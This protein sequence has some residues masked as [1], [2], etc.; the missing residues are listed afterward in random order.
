LEIARTEESEAEKI[1]YRSQVLSLELNVLTFLG[2]IINKLRWDP[3]IS[4]E[5]Q[6]SSEKRPSTKL[7]LLT[8]KSVLVCLGGLAE[9]DKARKSFK[10]R[11]V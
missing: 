9:V 3:S 7:P 2:N 11:R 1:A 4:G 5:L 10:A 6:Q 8:W